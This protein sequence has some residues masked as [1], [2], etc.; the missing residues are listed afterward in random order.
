VKV[1]QVPRFVAFLE[2]L[3][4]DPR[5]CVRVP[6]WQRKTPGKFAH[7]IYNIEQV[8]FGLIELPNQGTSDS[9]LPTPSRE[10]RQNP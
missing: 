5:G 2:E 9:H 7:V 10:N 1:L 6:R 8:P 3:L 4:H